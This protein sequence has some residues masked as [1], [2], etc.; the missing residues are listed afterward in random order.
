MIESRL[1]QPRAQACPRCRNPITVGWIVCPNCGQGLV[2]QA[3]APVQHYVM[4]P[5]PPKPNPWLWAVGLLAAFCV[6]FCAI[7]G[8]LQSASPKTANVHILSLTPYVAEVRLT[9]TSNEPLV[10][11]I[12][13]QVN[14]QPSGRQLM[15]E[16]ETEPTLLRPGQSRLARVRLSAFDV[17]PVPVVS[18]LQDREWRT[19]TFSVGD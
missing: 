1:M 5:E 7:G 12:D 17:S 11:S 16:E 14:R 10:L 19:V 6:A 18:K 4:M 15:I 8:Y 3:A 13:M 2:N 9:N